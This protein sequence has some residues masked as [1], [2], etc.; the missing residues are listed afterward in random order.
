VLYLIISIGE[1]IMNK[2]KQAGYVIE[3]DG[4]YDRALAKRSVGKGW[5]SLIDEIFDKLD[6]ME[7][8]PAVVQVKEKYAGLR[9]YL[10][11]YVEEV[12]QVII[13][14]EKK[15][16]KICETCGN[17][18]KVRGKRW[19]YTSCDEHAAVGDIPHLYQ[20]G[21]KDAEEEI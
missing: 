20:F 7:H 3:F 12:E 13:E 19:W 15:S 5:A 17:P 8:P 21:D 2:V 6:S 14:A 11:V 16:F 9:V 10:D 18:G 4:G 1:D